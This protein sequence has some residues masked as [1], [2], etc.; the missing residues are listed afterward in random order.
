MIMYD[1]V[2]GADVITLRGLGVVLAT[3]TGGTIPTTNTAGVPV[4]MIRCNPAAAVTAAVLAPGLYNGQ[5]VTVINEA[6]AANSITFDVAGTSNVADGAS[7]ALAGLTSREFVWD[8]A[9]A[10]WFRNA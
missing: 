4:G 6:I 8:T 7:A 9:A 3:A 2:R 10:R 5:K 1:S